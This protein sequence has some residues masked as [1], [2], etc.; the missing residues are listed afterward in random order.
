MFVFGSPCMIRDCRSSSLRVLLVIIL[1][2]LSLLVSASNDVRIE[3][4]RVLSA[5]PLFGALIT[6]NL[7]RSDAHYIRPLSYLRRKTGL[8]C[9]I[10]E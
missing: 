7:N 5:Y 10:P 8:T 3:T 4:I 1:Q 6:N 9:T 2:Q